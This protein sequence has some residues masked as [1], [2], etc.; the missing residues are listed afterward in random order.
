VTP[1][2]V[3]RWEWRTFGDD[4]G[5]AESRIAPLAAE[6]VQ[7]SDELYL[8]SRRSDAS[9]KVRD[10]L[11]DVKHLEE[12]NG[13]GLEQ[14]RPVLKAP[15]PLSQQN[16]ELLL[17]ELGVPASMPLRPSYTEDQVV[18]ELVGGSPDL[19]A[20]G[21]HKRRGRFTFA[22][23]MAELT[24]VRTDSG[25]TRTMA[26]EAED[27]G[28]VIAAVREL[29]LEQRPNTCLARGLKQL[30]GLGGVPAAVIDVGTNSVKFLI[31]E[32]SAD[33]SWRAVV[34][35]A[36]VTRLGEGVEEGGELQ[37]APVAR[38]AD[39]IV[40]MVDEARRHGV[41]EIAAVGTAGLRRASN[42]ELLIVAVRERCGVEIE[43]IS[44]DEE[45]R[46]AYLAATSAL[47][48]AD[49]TFVLF[50]SGGG[51]SQFTFAHDGD[52]DDRFSVPVG[53]VRFTERFGL[54][55]VVSEE[56]VA[57]ALEAIAA[58]LTQLDDRPSPDSIVGLGGTSTN[59]AAVLHNLTTYDP[60]VVNG[61]VLERDEIDRQIELFRT[62]T[63]E[64]RRELPGLQPKRA[65][66][67]LAGA[68]VVRSVLAKLDRP[69][70]TVSDR[71][72]RHRLISERFGSD[73]P[74]RPSVA[75]SRA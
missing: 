14:W 18:A 48:V 6:R 20:V 63:A 59:L 29:G 71:G 75:P 47:P 2:I 32:R 43:V 25:A 13:D 39:A 12:V 67:I 69:S 16:V 44:G 22:G 72:L 58:E 9:V 15:F 26:I 62:R 21:V 30:L 24:D 46:L 1:E 51:S 64:Q 53:A 38:T 49:G 3:P 55:G 4:F 60:E 45:A 23:C 61:T 65:E 40:S 35:R 70:L 36:E 27:P 34:D 8:L 17:A 10:G 74:A 11:M 7:E 37:P 28:A 19:T 57:A 66:V 41:T 33:G 50:D 42:P 52:I 68:L 31:G 56:T 5:L 73:D 54:D